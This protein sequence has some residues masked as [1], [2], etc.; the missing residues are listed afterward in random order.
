MPKYLFMAIVPFRCQWL[1]D[2]S[3][4]TCTQ[5]FEYQLKTKEQFSVRW[6]PL[7]KLWMGLLIAGN[8]R[9]NIRPQ[10]RSDRGERTLLLAIDDGG[11]G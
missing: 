7:V 8:R 4:A 1:N 10:P 9:R 5:Q 2:R 11:Q 6:R 3:Q